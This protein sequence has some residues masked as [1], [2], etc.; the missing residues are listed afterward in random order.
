MRAIKSTGI[1]E[2]KFGPW[3]RRELVRA[4]KLGLIL[5]VAGASFT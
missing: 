5:L 3:L 4:L 1:S 2:E